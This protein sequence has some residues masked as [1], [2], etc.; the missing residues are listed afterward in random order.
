MTRWDAAPPTP[1][2]RRAPA[3]AAT[4]RASE[5]R[6]RFAIAEPAEAI[7]GVERRDRE[8][9]GDESDQG[10]LA[11]HEPTRRRSKEKR[12]TAIRDQGD[13]DEVEHVGERDEALGEA[14]VARVQ[15][16]RFRGIPPCPRSRRRSPS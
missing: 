1:R 7:G 8:R 9:D 16:E 4:T 15:R 6:S 12:A 3:A 14:A 11:H 5:P 13:P 10:E 2:R